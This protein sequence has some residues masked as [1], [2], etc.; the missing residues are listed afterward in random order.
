MSPPM[1]MVTPQV[2]I[3]QFTIG[4]V[5]MSDK[6]GRIAM[7]WDKTAAVAPFTVAQ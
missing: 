5:D 3:D 6:G 4:F 7:A 2:S 1:K